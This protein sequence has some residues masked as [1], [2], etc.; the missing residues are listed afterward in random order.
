[1]TR[2]A[3]S[4]GHDPARIR[5]VGNGSPLLLIAGTGLS[6]ATWS[7]LFLER[8]SVHHTVI[9]YD[10]RGT[11]EWLDDGDYSTRQFADDAAKVL[12]ALELGRAHVLGHSMGGRIAQW[13]ALDHS[14]M[15]RTLILASSGPG[16]FPGLFPP[17][18]QMA[19]GI[20]LNLALSI[21]RLGLTRYLRQHLRDTFFTNAY[22]R[23]HPREV[24]DN[25]AVLTGEI[26]P[27]EAYYKQVIARQQ[28]QTA[29][30]LN[31][32]QAPTLVMVG[33]ADGYAAAAGD[34]R[35][36]SEFL[37]EAIPHSEMIP[38]HGQAH[39]Y[40]WQIPEE[41]AD[42]VTDWVARQERETVHGPRS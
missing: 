14:E 28:H 7:R 6:G 10:N 41:S 20:P 12:G 11:G 22:R 15:T 9:T 35:R 29:D 23:A 32:I 8:L 25:L 5:T 36:Q 34:H 42:I 18:R 31:E 13:L 38:L 4:A 33:D 1:M 24:R 37:Y 30:R 40:F 39:G 16:D 17:G 26:P 2:T 3:S 27:L 19:R 21:Q